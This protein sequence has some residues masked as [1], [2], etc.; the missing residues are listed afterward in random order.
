VNHRMMAMAAL[1]GLGLSLGMAGTT[2][3]AK[4]K[5]MSRQQ[6]MT[7]VGNTERYP[8]KQRVEKTEEQW[9]KLLSPE[10][11]RVTRKGGT[12]IAFTG[13]LWNN[14][15]AGT[16]RCA[17]CGLELFHSDTKFESGTGWPSFWAPVAR[18]NVRDISDHTLGM[19]RT[20]V[21]CNRCDAHLGHVFDDGPPPTGLRYCINSASLTFAAK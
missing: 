11:F 16:Y 15:R 17:D 2:G 18:V 10:V 21:V 5:R 12:E 14:H 3:A 1:V 19:P 6:A 20:E 4:E 7:L 9:K 13:A 8:A